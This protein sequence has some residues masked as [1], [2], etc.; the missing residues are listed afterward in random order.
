MVDNVRMIR[1]LGFYAPDG[2]E[3]FHE[4]RD[5]QLSYPDSL[6]RLR[7]LRERAAVTEGAFVWLG[8]FEPTRDE[9]DK[10]AELFEL[11]LLQVE[12]AAN[13]SHRP[14]LEWH[15]PR[16]ALL[17]VKMLDYVDAS[18]DVLT[19]QTSVFVGPD[20]AITV[21]FGQTRNLLGI[22]TRLGTDPS[23][24][25]VGP[26][27][28]MYAVLDNLVDGYLDVTSEI[29][30]DIADLETA[31]FAP[32]PLPGTSE[33]LYR[34]KRENV[35]IRRAVSPLV[36]TAHDMQGDRLPD[37]PQE[38][39]ALFHDVGEHILRAA[40]SAEWADN[41]L[42]SML[43]A[44][45]QMQDLQQNKD[46]R[47][48]SAWVGM[49]AVPTMIAGIYGMNFEFMPELHQSWGYPAILGLMGGACLLMYRFFKKSGW[50]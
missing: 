24:R 13:P 7:Q 26:L 49:A 46:M 32:M 40:E 15:G 41:L 34:L 14:V 35:E 43:T 2:V 45:T 10:I 29:A 31:V 25:A 33:R 44:A 9:L 18:S 22:R 11:R 42:M 20:F 4:G 23:L 17:I 5:W 8:L 37:L 30:T 1:G 12:D 6:P 36:G 28:V 16:D 27:A 47:K 21:R 48:I 38:L 50:L 3:E 19:G 39:R